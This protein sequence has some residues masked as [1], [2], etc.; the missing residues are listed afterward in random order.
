MA[1]IES[2]QSLPNHP[3]TLRLA[4]L[5]GVSIPQAIG[6]LH[7][8]WYWA[9]DYAEDGDIADGASILYRICQWNGDNEVL[10]EA[11]TTSGFLDE[12]RYIHNWAIYI[13]KLIERRAKD[14]DRKRQALPQTSVGVPTEGARIPSVTNQPTVNQPT[15]NQPTEE[16]YWLKLLREISGWDKR[17]E[18]HL[19][20]MLAW[21][22]RKQIQPHELESS[23]IGLGKVTTKILEGYGSLYK[24]FQDR[25]NKGYDRVTQPQR[26]GNNNEPWRGSDPPPKWIYRDGKK[27]PANQS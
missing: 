23:A 21:V 4:D 6:H 18:P 5:L 3:K 10:K 12:G 13:G 24:A 1:W 26:N 15:V 2:H 27:Y 25:I 9:T 11:L 8:L 7:L 16:Q 20:N 14:R 22:K 17:G 19:G